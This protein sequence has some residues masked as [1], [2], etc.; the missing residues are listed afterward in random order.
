MRGARWN[1][2]FDLERVEG[3]FCIYEKLNRIFVIF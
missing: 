1:L 3:Y 2:D